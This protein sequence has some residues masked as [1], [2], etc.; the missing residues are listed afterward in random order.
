MKV[1]AW[2][3]LAMLAWDGVLAVMDDEEEEIDLEPVYPDDMD[4]TK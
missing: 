2:L 1:F 3:L 4:E